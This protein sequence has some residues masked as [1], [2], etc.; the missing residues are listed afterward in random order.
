M[1]V[2]KAYATSV[3]KQTIDLTISINPLGC[4]PRALLAIRKLDSDQL[5]AYPDPSILITDLAKKFD[6]APSAIL[7]GNGSEQLIKLVS[8]AFVRQNDVVF[9]ESGSFFL[10]TREPLLCGAT[11]EFINF[12]TV[13]KS[14][15]KPT[16]L[17]IANPTT[18]SGTDRS[19]AALCSVIDTIKPRIVVIDEANGEF[20]NES[21]I[22]ELK[23][24]KNLIVLRTFS[25]ALGIAGLRIG[26]AFSISDIIATLNEFQQ[27]FPVTTPSL[28]AAVETL[29]DDIFLKQTLQFIRSERKFL[30]VAL[31]KRGFDVAPSITNNL[32]VSRVENDA[33]INGLAKRNVGVID[34][35]FF[36]DNKKQGFRISLKD[37][38]TNRVFLARLDE[39]LACLPNKK[40]LPSKENL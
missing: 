10:F 5:S 15:N 1:N 31:T 33:I 37:K 13:R 18:P 32:F 2:P 17:F 7:L 30:T 21:M 39:V 19:N 34:G 22:A 38:K 20:R 14:N 9:V 3:K 26:A 6:V 23:N 11:V 36:P 29:K 28:V 4:S 8:Q 16:L 25:K 40:L 24:F 27:P 35:V 12:T